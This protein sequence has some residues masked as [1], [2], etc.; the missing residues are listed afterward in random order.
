MEISFNRRKKNTHY[1][2]EKKI[3]LNRF[4][5]YKCLHPLNKP[6]SY[7]LLCV[8]MR[9]LSPYINVYEKEI[10]RK[11]VNINVGGKKKKLYILII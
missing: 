8:Y 5:K 2:A 11:R 7:I 9:V 6:Y 3:E 10:Q 1:T 4:I